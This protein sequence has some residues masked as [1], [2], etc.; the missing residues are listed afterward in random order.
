MG[1]KNKKHLR[2]STIIHPMAI[3]PTAALWALVSIVAYGS[4]VAL[5]LPLLCFLYSTYVYIEII[6]L[7]RIFTIVFYC[8]CYSYLQCIKF[9]C[10]WCLH[11]IVLTLNMIETKLKKTHQEGLS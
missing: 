3:I 5:I 8:A 6:I 10:R 4:I 1:S 11:I 7:S 9:K 2:G